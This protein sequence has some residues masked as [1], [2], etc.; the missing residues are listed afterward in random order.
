MFFPGR[1]VSVLVY[2]KQILVV[3][4]SEKQKKKKSPLLVFYRFHL[5]LNFHPF[6][7]FPCL[8]FPGRSA[9]ISRL[10]F[11]GGAWYGTA[12]IKVLA[13]LLRVAVAIAVLCY[14]KPIQSVRGIWVSFHTVSS[15]MCQMHV[16]LMMHK[17]HLFHRKRK[18]LVI[19]DKGNGSTY[20]SNDTYVTRSFP[21]IKN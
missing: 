9:E 10:E 2:P 11:W 17:I 3:L 21:D 13:Q 18:V 14:M 5:L 8:F 12:L 19:F 1:K 15:T 20:E 4:K 7:L 16:F 6:F